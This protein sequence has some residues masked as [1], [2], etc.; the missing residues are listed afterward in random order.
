[1]IEERQMMCGPTTSL[2]VSV[3][4]VGV[5]ISVLTKNDKCCWIDKLVHV[6]IKWLVV[7]IQNESSSKSQ[8]SVNGVH[9]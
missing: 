2:L 5:G 8:G 1:M 9:A 7:F 3:Q 6:A 4:W